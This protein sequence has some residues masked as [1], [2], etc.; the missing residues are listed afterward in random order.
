MINK[1]YLMKAYNI[2]RIL[3]VQIN[4]T[5]RCFCKC[6]MCNKYKWP[7]IELSREQFN[8]RLIEFKNID[9][10]V[11]S[12]GEP[13]GYEYLSDILNYPQHFG[14]FTSGIGKN[15]SNDILLKKFDWIR[16]SIDGFSIIHN[17][18]R[19]ANIWQ[20][21][22]DFA[23]YCRNLGIDTRIQYTIQNENVKDFI[24]FLE[25]C[26]KQLHIPCFGF[27]VQGTSILSDDNKNILV[28]DLLK[29]IGD[30]RLVSDSNVMDIFQQ[31]YSEPYRSK[32]CIIFKFHKIIDAD[33]TEWPCCYTMADNLLYEFRNIE[34]ECSNKINPKVINKETA[35]CNA[36][37]AIFSRYQRINAEYEQIENAFNRSIFL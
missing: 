14:I 20:K 24:L 6:I 23:L 33:N 16:I 30:K 13:F 5:N 11:L 4:V 9:S 28:A 27:L 8:S 2:A 31:I 3:S 35:F 26:I 21:A 22:R 18:I 34:Y 32:K 12:G 36:C 10:I 29:I 15:C 37:D 1:L 17:K 19:Q 25:Y 7:N